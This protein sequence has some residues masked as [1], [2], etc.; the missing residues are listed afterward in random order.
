MSSHASLYPYIS[1]DKNIK[2]KVLIEI[3]TTR[4]ILADQDSTKYFYTL[5]KTF[6]F[7]FITVDMDKEN[8]DNIK[9]RLPKIN[10]VTQKG[11]DFL[12]NYTDRIDYVY[13]DAFDFYHPNHA[14]IRIEKYR[15]ILGT[16]INN[17]ACHQMHLECCESLVHKLPSGGIILFDDILNSNYDGKG[18]TAIP[19][20]IKNNFELIKMVNNGCILR[21]K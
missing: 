4:E 8:T 6:G 17:A 9:Q 13:L 2:S 11:E 18:K 5:S 10:A 1:Q 7:H 16:T 19:F 15:N 12:R 3:G 14:Q 21:K 20:L